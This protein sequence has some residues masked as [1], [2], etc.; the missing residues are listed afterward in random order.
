M[1]ISS[2]QFL[3]DWR[4]FKPSLSPARRR[5]NKITNLAKIEFC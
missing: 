3:P 4:F 5:F 1:M 2:I